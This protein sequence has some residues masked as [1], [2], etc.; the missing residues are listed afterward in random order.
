MRYPDCQRTDGDWAVCSLVNYNRDCRNNPVSRLAYL[1][2][3][4]GLKQREL[5]EKSGINIR[6]IQRIENGESEM[7][8]VTLG[9]AIALADALNVDVKE[10][11]E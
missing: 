8:N 6:Q 2:T 3:G 11:L 7:R 1:R 9:N 4:A 5:A 10:L